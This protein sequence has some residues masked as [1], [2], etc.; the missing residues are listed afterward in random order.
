MISLILGCLLPLAN[1]ADIG[2]SANVQVAPGIAVNLHSDSYY[3]QRDRDRQANLARI[4]ADR[5]AEQRRRDDYD[6]QPVRGQGSLFIW[7][8]TR[9]QHAKESQ[10]LQSQQDAHEKDRVTQEQ[11]IHSDENQDRSEHQH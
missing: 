10:R 5:D 11:K 2:L 7:R 9:D 1:G 3:A 8:D 4:Q 6:R